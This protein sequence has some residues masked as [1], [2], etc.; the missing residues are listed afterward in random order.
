VEALVKAAIPTRDRLPEKPG[1]KSYEQIPCLIFV[2][3]DWEISVWN[4]EHLCWDDASGDD[5]RYHPNKPDL[6]LPLPYG[7]PLVAALAAIRAGGK[8]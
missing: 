1:L 5:F 4:C 8:P 6:W 3:G 2:D 7:E